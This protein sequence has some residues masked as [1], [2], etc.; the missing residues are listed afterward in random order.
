MRSDARRQV[1]V[2]APQVASQGLQLGQEVPWGLIV[3]RRFRHGLSP[4]VDL[5]PRRKI[6]AAPCCAAPVMPRGPSGALVAPTI[7]G[8]Y[9]EQ[10]GGPSTAPGGTIGPTGGG[11]RRYSVPE[12]ARVLGISE[13][14]VRK[15]ITVSSLDAERTPQ[16]WRVALAA[17]PRAVPVPPRGTIEA[18]PAEP[19][20]PGDG[21]GAVPLSDPS[22]EVIDE[23]HRQRDQ[24]EATVDDL[25]RRLDFSEHAQAELRRLLAAALQQRALAAPTAKSDASENADPWWVRWWP[26]RRYP[27]SAP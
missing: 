27:R 5:H 25:R 21:T 9:A 7:V 20:V 19:A 4:A 23:L 11:T 24:L 12:A 22:R 26:W 17:V 6:G 18:V 3:G 2:D 16:G 15:R 1:V 8:M 10:G 14:A 13:R